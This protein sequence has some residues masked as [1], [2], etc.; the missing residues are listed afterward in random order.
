MKIDFFYLFYNVLLLSLS[1]WSGSHI[2]WGQAFRLRH[3][4]TGH[5]LART[6]DKGLVLQDREK[7]DTKATA[8]CF[9]SSKVSA[10]P[11]QVPSLP[12]Y[13]TAV[14]VSM[15]QFTS[16]KGCYMTHHHHLPPFPRLFHHSLLRPV[17]QLS[18]S[19]RSVTEPTLHDGS[20]EVAGV[21][22]TFH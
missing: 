11:L 13:L 5:Y 14:V 19:S 10:P 21:K 3:L 9:R 1:S 7:S 20:S 4:S 18:I 12:V 15:N 17:C 16:L 8:F 22:P 2:R 6:E